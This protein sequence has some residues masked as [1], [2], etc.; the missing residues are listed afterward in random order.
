MSADSTPNDLKE[1]LDRFFAKLFSEVEQ[2]EADQVS[3]Q[4]GKDGLKIAIN[5]DAT[6]IRCSTA[7]LSWFEPI[8]EWLK[9]HSGP[10]AKAALLSDKETSFPCLVQLEGTS[11]E[12]SV[13]LSS[14]DTP[15]GKVTLQSFNNKPSYCAPTKLARPSQDGEGAIDVS[16][17]F[18]MGNAEDIRQKLGVKRSRALIL[19]AEDDPDQRDLIAMVLKDEKYDVISCGDGDEA[20][21]LLQKEIPDLVITDVMMPGVDG[22]ELI[23]RLKGEARTKNI[24]V[25]VLTVLD[26]REKEF[27]LLSLGADDYCEKTMQRKILL[28]RVENLLKRSKRAP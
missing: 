15:N 19:L 7:K 22:P 14:D 12:C 3:F 1:R 11:I 27:S 23:K 5:R 21:I 6:E 8:V 9:T 24:P 4:T 17:D 16:D 25:L 28:K 26:D 13:K 18:F 20:W 10:G 2:L